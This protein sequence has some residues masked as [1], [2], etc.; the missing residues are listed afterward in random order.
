MQAPTCYLVYPLAIEEF[1]LAWYCQVFII[2]LVSMSRQV[3]PPPRVDF[4][5]LRKCDAVSVPG[6]QLGNILDVRIENGPSHSFRDVLWPKSQLATIILSPTV[7]ESI[8]IDGKG[9]SMAAADL[10]NDLILQRYYH[11]WM[12]QLQ[13]L[14]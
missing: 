7:H 6:C 14:V 9:V 4:L 12:H 11:T 1:H 13:A 2:L 10:P 3:S 8:L 5:V